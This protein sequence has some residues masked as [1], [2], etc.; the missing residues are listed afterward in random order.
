MKF[1]N[2]FS[3]GLCTS[4]DINKGQG[5]VNIAKLDKNNGENY[6]LWAKVKEL[7]WGCPWRP[8]LLLSSDTYVIFD[9]FPNL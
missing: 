4:H 9:G 6:G 7:C 2:P 1:C 3:S 5:H 8:I